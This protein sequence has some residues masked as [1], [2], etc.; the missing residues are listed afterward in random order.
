VFVQERASGCYHPA[1]YYIVKILFDLLPLR[2]LPTLLLGSLVYILTGLKKEWVA[3]GFF[4][5]V[6]VLFSITTTLICISIATGIRNLALANLISIITLLFFMLFQGAMI[7]FGFFFF[8]F[9]FPNS[10]L[11]LTFFFFLSFFLFFL[12]KTEALPPYIHWMTFL[13]PFRFGLNSLLVNEL[14]GLSI[15]FDPIED[16]EVII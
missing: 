5:A 16:M 11:L 7:N 12:K 1:A 15:W 2:I 10:Y 8:L 3:Y 14:D 4:I 13:S 6:I 9:F